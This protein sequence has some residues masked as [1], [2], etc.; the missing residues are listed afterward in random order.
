MCV[1]DA[2]PKKY[3]KKIAESVLLCLYLFSVAV[4]VAVVPVVLIR[5]GSSSF[6]NAEGGD[7]RRR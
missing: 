5:I 3:F 6:V 7:G 1:A 2:R 4:V